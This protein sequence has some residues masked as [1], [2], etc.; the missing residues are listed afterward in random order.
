MT[1]LGARSF[2][3]LPLV[4]RLLGEGYDV[5]A[6]SR[7]PD[8]LPSFATEAYTKMALSQLEASDL[9][10]LLISLMPIWQTA[11]LLERL[12]L[13]LSRAVVLSSSSI[14]NKAASDQAL[15]GQLAE[16]EERLVKLFD[17]HDIRYLMLR[18]SL[19]FGYGQDQNVSFIL[20]S[21]KRYHIMPYLG[22][23]QGIRQPI[24][25]DDLA[26][27]I[28]VALGTDHSA[29]RIA[30][31]GLP[32]AYKEMVNVLAGATNTAY[33]ALHLPRG[34]VRAAIAIA[35]LL[36]RYKFMDMA[37]FERMNEDLLVDN[38]LA[39]ALLNHKPK[40]FVDSLD[41]S[42]F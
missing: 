20:K 2:V 27:A 9:S 23:A 17:S 40:R 42:Y 30:I 10:G 22:E 24:H 5:K 12:R 38:S 18:P 37:M 36:P 15:V 28:A 29:K 41:H 35:S 21:L 11:A 14:I 1:V 6:V 26:E 7:Q 8:K 33:V 34:L 39:K 4:P 25:A 3:A 31:G 13:K 16:A 19:I 32:I